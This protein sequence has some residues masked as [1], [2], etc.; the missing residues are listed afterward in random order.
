MNTDRRGFL[1]AI[2]KTLL[3]V[4]IAGAA[5]SPP[6][7]ARLQEFRFPNSAMRKY[8]WSDR[9]G[10]EFDDI[11]DAYASR[12]LSLVDLCSKPDGDMLRIYVSD[13][14]QVQP[15]HYFTETGDEV[16]VSKQ[17]TSVLGPFVYTY[18]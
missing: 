5:G 10:Q 8:R 6:V 18:A 11:T 13:T 14:S 1:G 15:F 16:L 4:S 3:T 12:G 7:V 2:A 9:P 17:G